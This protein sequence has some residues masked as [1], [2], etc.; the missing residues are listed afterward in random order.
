MKPRSETSGVSLFPSI[1]S[2]DSLMASVDR[3]SPTPSAPVAQRGPE[4]LL[5]RRGSRGVLGLVPL[6]RSA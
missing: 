2:V 6:G 1:D 4:E 5:A 3:S